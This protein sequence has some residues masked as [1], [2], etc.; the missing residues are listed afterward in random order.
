[1]K[2]DTAEAALAT[3]RQAINPS[4]SVPDADLPNLA[5]AHRVD[6]EKVDE[7]Q[8]SAD[9]LATLRGKASVWERR[10]KALLMEATTAAISS[11]PRKD[12]KLG[13]GIVGAM[14][15]IEEQIRHAALGLPDTE[16]T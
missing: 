8:Q 14:A 5:D 16:T 15:R 13:A 9:D 1:V 7:W 11:D 2:L 10:W 6:S 12:S 3:L 4:G